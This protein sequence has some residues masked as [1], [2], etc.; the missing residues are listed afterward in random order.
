MALDALL[1]AIGGK[2][3]SNAKS[4]SVKEQMPPA[5]K[6]KKKAIDTDLP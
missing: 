4:I 2:W 5:V 1:V 3:K 6:G